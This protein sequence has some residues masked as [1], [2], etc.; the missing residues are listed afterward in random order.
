MAQ[1]HDT[2]RIQIRT[3]AVIEGPR[4]Y[5]ENISTSLLALLV[6]ALAAP[7]RRERAVCA[8]FR[9]EANREGLD[10]DDVAFLLMACML[11]DDR[12]ERDEAAAA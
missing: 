3:H 11:S 7:P 8:A 6:A 2:T 4:D 1:L 10:E 5:L 12:D 9:R